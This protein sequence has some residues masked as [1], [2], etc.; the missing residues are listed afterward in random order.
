M[1]TRP[2]PSAASSSIHP[3]PAPFDCIARVDVAPPPIIS[4]VPSPPTAN[5]APGVVVPIPILVF[6]A[7]NLTRGILAEE[8]AYACALAFVAMVVV[9][10]LVYVNDNPSKVTPFETRKAEVEAWL[11]TPRK[12]EVALVDVALIIFSQVMVEVALFTKTPPERVV[13]PVTLSVVAADKLPDEDI[14][15]PKDVAHTEAPTAI[16]APNTMANIK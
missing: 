7:S 10:T 16:K 13:F 8:V 4:A 9:L 11:V 12:V 14:F 5:V 3:P 6:D 15:V 1:A 2:L